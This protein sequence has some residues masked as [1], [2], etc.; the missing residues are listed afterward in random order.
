MY[1]ARD[2]ALPGEARDRGWLDY[3]PRGSWA[4]RRVSSGV[5]AIVAGA[6]DG[7]VGVWVAG[8]EAVLVG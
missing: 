3:Q 5:Q 2:R 1:P 7:V 4:S 6:G 8:A